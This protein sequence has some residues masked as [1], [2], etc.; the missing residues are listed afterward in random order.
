MVT[1]EIE[2]ESEIKIINISIRVFLSQFRVHFMLNLDWITKK[3]MSVELIEG[4][5]FWWFTV[6]IDTRQ[7]DF[8]NVC[9]CLVLKNSSSIISSDSL[10]WSFCYQF[11]RLTT[12]DNGK[13]FPR[14]GSWH[15]FFIMSVSS[16]NELSRWCVIWFCLRDSWDHFS[17]PSRA[18]SSIVLINE[19]P[20][21]DSRWNFK[22]SREGKNFSSCG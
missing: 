9:K 11:K 15:D 13:H 6:W 7:R 5:R 3:M 2:R 1:L 14:I 21:P 22:L 10:L 12:R 19:S 18:P 16:L 8:R 17:S 20:A 4:T